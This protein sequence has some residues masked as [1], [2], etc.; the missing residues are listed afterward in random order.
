MGLDDASS[1]IMAQDFRGVNLRAG[2]E[3]TVASG[4]EP[5]DGL[6]R[7]YG[8]AVAMDTGGDF[9]VAWD[10]TDDMASS[11]DVMAQR[12]TAD[13]VPVGGPI[14]VQH[15]AGLPDRGP[16][17]AMD[18]PG[19]FVVAYTNTEVDGSKHV[20]AALF[21]AQG[22]LSQ[23]L[24]LPEAQGTFE[25]DN[26]SVAEAPDGR[27]A[28]AF[29]QN[30]QA[31]L[32]RFSPAG[33]ELSSD[34]LQPN[35]RQSWPSVSMDASGNCVV[36]WE[37]PSFHIFAERVS[38]ADVLGGVLDL[39]GGSQPSVALVPS[40]PSPTAGGN[41][42]VAYQQQGANGPVPVVTEVTQGDTVFT[43]HILSGAGSS[44]ARLVE[45]S[46]CINANNLYLVSFTEDQLGE[47]A[48]S[49]TAQ[50]GVLVNPA[51]VNNS[52]PNDPLYGGGGGAYPPFLN[53]GPH[54]HLIATHPLVHRLR[55]AHR[56]RR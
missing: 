8:P 23:R 7:N 44:P 9:V 5:F 37:G 33:V 22:A 18:G 46:I 21:N 31:R 35:A 51:P 53:W 11:V 43:N 40:G 2:G 15:V 34:L 3:I 17:V 49:I 26:V 42:V 56:K 39:G 24:V 27:F 52:L 19:N 32:D 55:S 10:H 12:F 13:G 45:P 1:N 54:H 28:I 25:Q 30:G 14:V 36:A 29:M 4:V 6:A 47:Q 20:E 48:Q 50:V 16:S 38:S 41:F